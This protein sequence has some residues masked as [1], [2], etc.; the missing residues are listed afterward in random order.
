MRA[1]WATDIGKIRGRTDNLRRLHTLYM[2]CLCVEASTRPQTAA[3][4]GSVDGPTVSAHGTLDW[5]ACLSRPPVCA[6]RV[7]SLGP[8]ELLCMMTRRTYLGH[9]EIGSHFS[10]SI[11]SSRLSVAAVDC[12]S[13]CEHPATSRGDEKAEQRRSSR[14]RCWT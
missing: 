8:I 11:R 7:A 12:L 13:A 4:T 6:V 14:V 2:C 9:A 3:A 1:P 5:I 10:S